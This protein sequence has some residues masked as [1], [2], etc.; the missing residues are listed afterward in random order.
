MSVTGGG[1]PTTWVPGD[2][3]ARRHQ[4]RHAEGAVLR[5][6]VVAQVVDIST[7]GLGLQ[8]SNSLSPLSRQLFTLSMGRARI[9]VAGEV[10]WCRLVGTL[11]EHDGAREPVYR[12]G[13]AL[14]EP[15]RLPLS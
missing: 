2:A 15:I 8:T 3:E 7:R 11:T 10:R 5:N 12:A 6:P 4:R 13:V 1:P 14:F 9:S